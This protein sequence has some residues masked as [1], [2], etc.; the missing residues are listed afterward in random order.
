MPKQRYVILRARPDQGTT[1]IASGTKSQ[2]PERA[3]AFWVDSGELTRAEVRMLAGETDVIAVAPVMPA[4]VVAPVRPRDRRAATRQR[5]PGRRLPSRGAGAKGLTRDSWGIAEIGADLSTVGGA[6]VRVAVLDTGID[7][8]HK[9]FGGVKNWSQRNFTLEAGMQD[10]SGHGTACAA[11]I[12]G[13]DVHGARIG[14]ARDVRDVSIGKICRNDA[15]LSTDTELIFK[16][17]EW[18]AL[19]EGVQVISMSVAVDFTKKV[20][21]LVVDQHLPRRQAVSLALEAYRATVRMFDAL[22][23]TIRARI[24]YD[25]GAVVVAA[26]GND[27]TLDFKVGT[28]IPGAADGILSVGALQEAPGDTDGPRIVPFYSNTFVT[29]VAPGERIKTARSGGNLTVASGTSLA[30]PHVAGAAA[31]WWQYL[32]ESGGPAD[33]RSVV[34]RLLESATSANIAVSTP[35]EDRGAGVVRAPPA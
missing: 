13:Q 23:D 14:V 24:P 15:H 27:S 25:G 17:L 4:R 1:D 22:M 6:G 7:A 29:L 33:S 12:F 30:A 5:K 34:G 26:A 32:R 2:F 8:N 16:G 28:G 35:A 31:L 21:D 11:T 3:P 10:T 18:A 19:D 20:E 9:A